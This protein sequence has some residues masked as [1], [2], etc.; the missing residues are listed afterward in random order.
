[1]GFDVREAARVD[2]KHTA[3]SL[4][5]EAHFSGLLLKPFENRTSQ[6][7]GVAIEYFFIF[8]T[9]NSDTI[10]TVTEGFLFFHAVPM[11]HESVDR[12]HGVKIQ[13]NTTIKGNQK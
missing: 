4:Y 13:I 8:Q 9:F 6:R 10:G 3:N 11:I 2:R 12:S 7:H 1:M 5:A